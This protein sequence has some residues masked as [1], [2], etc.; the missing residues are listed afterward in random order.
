M[1]A[2]REIDGILAPAIARANEVKSVAFP[3]EVL[4]ALP[5]VSDGESALGNLLADWMRSTVPDADAGIAN[6]GGVRAALPAGVLTFGRLYAVT[7]F[8]NR[9]G[10]DAVDRR[11]AQRDGPRQPADARQLSLVVRSARDRQLPGAEPGRRAAPGVVRAAR[12]A[13]TRC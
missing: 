8:D 13:T 2:S 11:A 7:P 9:A 10:N 12:S 5:E 4:D 3:A 1:I 6:S